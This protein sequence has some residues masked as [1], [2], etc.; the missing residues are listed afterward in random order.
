MSISKSM[1][2]T[3]LKREKAAEADYMFIV[4]DTFDYENYPVYVSKEKF[5]ENYDRYNGRN[6]QKIIEIYD[7]HKDI[8]EQLN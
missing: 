2:R 3:W 7:L 6:K 8:D 5:K 4:C 1:I